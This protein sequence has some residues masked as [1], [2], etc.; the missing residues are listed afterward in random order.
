QPYPVIY[1]LSLHDAL[2][3]YAIDVVKCRTHLTRKIFSQG[4]SDERR[5]DRRTIVEL[6]AFA[7]S[8]INRQSVRCARPA[9]REPRAQ[10]AVVHRDRKSTRL[11][12]SHQIISYA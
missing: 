1:P 10:P 4:L 5:R 11:N 7:K 2:P 8:N 9:L 6:A 12:S 3:I